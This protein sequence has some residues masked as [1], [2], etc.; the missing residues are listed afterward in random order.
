MLVQGC[1][2]L[3]V[4]GGTSGG[5]DISGKA[6]LADMIILFNQDWFNRGIDK[7][8]LSTD[9]IEDRELGPIMGCLGETATG[10]VNTTLNSK[11][12]VT[13][14]VGRDINL[15]EILSRQTTKTI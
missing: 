9:R 4:I 1:E 6:S 12:G 14:K 13:K 7:S 2:H 10:R 3:V 15:K 8:E 11:L 5:D